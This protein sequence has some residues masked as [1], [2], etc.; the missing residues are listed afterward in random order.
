MDL[1]TIDIILRIVQ[2]V[3]LPIVGW[4]IKLLHDLRRD[5]AALELRVGQIETCLASVPSESALHELALS[6]TGLRGDLKVAVEKI[7]GLGKVVSRVEQ[8][9]GRHED[10]LLNGGAHK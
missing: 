6:I 4:L 7:D 10:Y 2:I 1:P 9:V 3:V 8:V 5:S